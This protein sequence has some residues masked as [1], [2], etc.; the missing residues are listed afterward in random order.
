MK[1]IRYQY[2]PLTIPQAAPANSL[3]QED[4]VLDQ[5]FNR[6]TGIAVTQ[7]IPDAGLGNA[8]L[9]GAK[10]QRQVWIDQIPYNL[11]N[12][13]EGVSPNDKYYEVNIPY[14]SKDTF[15]FQAINL[16]ALSTNDAELYMVLRLEIDL[17]ELPQR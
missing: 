6:I 15:Y 14:G 4:V 3:T 8:I 13:D 12:A 16:A 1:E 17:T 9:I 2:I 5:A 10:T 11:W 7:V